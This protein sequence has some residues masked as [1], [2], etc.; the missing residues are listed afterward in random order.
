MRDSVKISIPQPCAERWENFSV[1]PHGGFCGSCNKTVVDFT[2]MS[3]EE[4]LNFFAG[5]S[6]K[7]CGRFRAD[8]LKSYGVKQLPALRPGITLLRAG[9]VGL[10][11]VLAGQFSY[12]QQIE[13]KQLPRTEQV[14][15]NG[16]REAKSTSEGITAKGI[17]READT[18][19]PVP[20]VNVV[21]KGTPNGTVTDARG[22]FEFPVKV[23][24]G[25]VLIFSFIGFPT[26]EHVVTNDQKERDIEINLDSSV[27]VLGKVAVDEPYQA[28]RGLSAVWWKVKN[29][30]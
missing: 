25:D 6:A 16:L 13:K 4:V 10:M 9:F 15:A 1:T 5:N 22:H 19:D 18:G 14:P 2:S 21:L 20:G 3:D 17:V 29:I 24:T 28:P 8:Q 30:F 12:A 27:I 7:T 11:V 23:N 26:V